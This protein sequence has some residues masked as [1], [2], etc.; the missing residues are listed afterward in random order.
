MSEFVPDTN[1]RFLSAAFHFF[2]GEK[3]DILTRKDIVSICRRYNLSFPQWISGDVSR[4]LQRGQYS[5]P[6][7]LELNEKEI[8]S[9]K[10]F[11]VDTTVEMATPRVKK[12]D[13]VNL[14]AL[15]GA[16]S[17]EQVDYNDPNK[18]LVPRKAPGYVPFGP[19]PDIRDIIASRI[20][21]TCFITGLSGNGKTISVEQACHAT[22]RELI[23][24]PITAETDEDDLLGG[25]RLHDGATVWEDGPVVRAME[26]GAVLLLDEVDLGTPKLMC[27]Q[28]VLDGR[29]LYIKKINRLII[30]KE[31]FNVFAT[32]NTKGQ[33]SDSGQFIGTNIMNEAFLERFS[34]TI[35]Q[36]YPPKAVETKILNNNLKLL[37]KEDA[38]FV[39]HLVRWAEH[40]RITHKESGIE[41][42][43][44][45]RRLVH[46]IKAFV[47]MGMDRSK[48]LQLC[49]N[50]YDDATKESFMSFYKIIDEKIRKEEEEARMKAEMEAQKK[51]GTFV[52]APVIKE[53]N[54]Q[55]KQEE[56][57]DYIKNMIN[58]INKATATTP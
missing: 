14:D 46:I 29:A 5:V 6:E 49:L 1:I 57:T 37:G 17:H 40:I 33:G 41:Y 4:R 32:G 39:E 25:F 50:R 20:F 15:K 52:E 36:D 55:E 21:Y 26:R 11:D 3:S 10:D 45:T 18:V 9:E 28:P 56:M 35:E 43:M 47:I 58:G 30:P 54:E 7:F 44:S 42:T 19:Y 24:V 34:I 53:M 13:G 22:E 16:A 38:N 12:L 2:N 8:M 51:A 31:G 27:L 23:V 48:A